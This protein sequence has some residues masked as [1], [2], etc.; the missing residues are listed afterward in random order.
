MFQSDEQ[1][2]IPSRGRSP[3]SVLCPPSSILRPSAG[4]IFSRFRCRTAALGGQMGLFQHCFTADTFCFLAS[5][6]VRAQ[7][8]V[9]LCRTRA[10]RPAAVCP[11]GQPFGS[12]A[13]GGT[14]GAAV[15]TELCCGPGPLLA[16]ME[17]ADSF[18]LD[19]TC[20]AVVAMETVVEAVRAKL[21][22]LEEQRLELSLCPTLW[23]YKQ[24]L[25][26]FT[27]KHRLKSNLRDPH[28]VSSVNFD[29]CNTPS[30]PCSHPEELFK[31]EPR[32]G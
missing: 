13:S 25:L 11:G 3:S 23:M 22:Q 15:G 8:P 24:T 28:S 17:P 9:G 32:R 16:Q 10:T 30:P 7:N 6:V 31:V 19:R 5:V 14:V 4:D 2:Q 26:T 27:N 21:H 12:A 29:P 20:A 1:E 18:R